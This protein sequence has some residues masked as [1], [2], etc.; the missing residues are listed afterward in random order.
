[1]KACCNS[2]LMA[3]GIISCAHHVAALQ[4]PGGD[5][6]ARC[7]SACLFAVL[8]PIY[9]SMRGVS[10]SEVEAARDLGAGRWSIL[11]TVIVPRCRAASSRPSAS[12]S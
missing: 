11:S 12:S 5:R 3:M 9:A 8:P 6:H 2:A 4:A 7:I 1:M 10:D